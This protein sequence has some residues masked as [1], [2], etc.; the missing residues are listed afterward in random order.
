MPG[1]L[2]SPS[3]MRRRRLAYSPSICGTLSIGPVIAA[4]AAYCAI[5]VG[6]DVD[7]LCSFTVAV[8]ISAGA[9][10]YPTRHPVI[11]KVFETEPM[12]MTLSFEPATLATENG[13]CGA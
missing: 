13:L 7:W 2:L 5:E 6:F 1:I 9:S 12:I 3:T 10:V 8:I 11:A 4:S